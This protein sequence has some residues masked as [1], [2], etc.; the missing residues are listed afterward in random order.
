MIMKLVGLDG[1][2]QTL[3]KRTLQ[4]KTHNGNIIDE[5]RQMRSRM[6]RGIESVVLKVS[7]NAY[8]RMLY[9]TLGFVLK[10]LYC[11][12]RY[13]NINKYVWCRI[14]SSYIYKEQENRKRRGIMSI[15][16]IFRKL[17]YHSLNCSWIKRRLK[18]CSGINII[19]IY[20]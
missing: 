7:V 12:Y 6:S 8:F 1:K 4:W 3:S 15:A 13:I 18:S 5:M 11:T 2:I 17:Y 10:I 19:R 20:F 9:I 16:Q 14:K